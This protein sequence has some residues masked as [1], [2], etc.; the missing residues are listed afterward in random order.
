MRFVFVRGRERVRAWEVG[1]V[2]KMVDGE[3]YITLLTWAVNEI[4]GMLAVKNI[5]VLF[6]KQ[7]RAQV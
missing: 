4:Q 5:P 2:G 6:L 1:V 7:K 3:R